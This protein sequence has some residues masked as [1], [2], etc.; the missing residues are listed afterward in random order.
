MKGAKYLAAGLVGAFIGIFAMEYAT[1]PQRGYQFDK[2]GDGI[3]DS[4][5]VVD[6]RG[7]VTDVTLNFADFYLNKVMDD[8]GN[9]KAPDPNT[10]PSPKK[11]YKPSPRRRNFSQPGN[12]YAQ[13]NLESKGL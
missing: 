12:A 1:K 7:K 5:N 10:P 11:P 9:R 4:F 13:S 3:N 6:R 8:I 2:D